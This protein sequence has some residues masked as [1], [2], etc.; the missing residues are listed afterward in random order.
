MS[1]ICDS[2]R[3]CS[4]PTSSFISA[5]DSHFTVPN[6]ASSPAERVREAPSR[7]SLYDVHRFISL[8]KAKLLALLIVLGCACNQALL[9]YK[10]GKCCLGASQSKFGVGMGICVFE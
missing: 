7:G 1:E 4:A 5:P 6:E 3:G 10:Y 9:R 8:E 2:A